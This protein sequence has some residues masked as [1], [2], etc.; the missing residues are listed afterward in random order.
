MYVLQCLMEG[1][2][3]EPLNQI[4]TSVG[5][6]MIPLCSCNTLDSRMSQRIWL[7]AIISLKGKVLL[8][9]CKVILQKSFIMSYLMV[10]K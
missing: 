7:E 10:T 3:R 2:F 9:K 4:Q 8:S 6:I 5:I 1:N